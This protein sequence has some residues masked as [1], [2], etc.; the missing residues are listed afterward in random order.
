MG[1]DG[2]LD[3]LRGALGGLRDAILRLLGRGEPP[4]AL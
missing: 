2:L 4:P 3:L 1:F